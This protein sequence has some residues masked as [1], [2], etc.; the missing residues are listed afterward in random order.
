MTIFP[1]MLI[2]AS[3]L[4]SHWLDELAMF[5]LSENESAATAVAA[6]RHAFDTAF[7]ALQASP[8]RTAVFNARRE[9]FQKRKLPSAGFMQLLEQNRYQPEIAQLIESLNS[10]RKHLTLES[11]N[12]QE[13]ESALLSN[14]HLLQRVARDETLCRALL[15]ASHDLLERL[16]SFAQ[17]SVETFI[18]KDRQIALSL[19]QYL[20]RA[21]AKTSPLSR[22][23]TVG[24]KRIGQ[25]TEPGDDFAS[26]LKPH[27]TPNV[28]LL[29]ALY[30]VLLREIAFQRALSV[31]LNPCITH[32]TEESVRSADVPRSW[33][34]F[35]G[36][37]EAFQ[38][39]GANP[40]ADVVVKTLLGYNR[41][42]PFPQLLEY[43]ED[44]IDASQEQL[45][46][47]VYEL[48][49]YGLLEWELPEKGLTPG[50][51]GALYQFLGFLTDQPPVVSDAAGLLQWLRTAAR[52]LSFQ[53]LGA[54]MA[55]QREAV[56]MSHAFFENYGGKMPPIPPEQ[57]F[58]EDVAEMLA[59]DVPD[60]VIQSLANELAECWRQRR[61]KAFP[62]L[63]AQI[64]S[65]AEKELQE[66]QTIDFPVFYKRFLEH[67]K[68]DRPVFPKYHNTT[69]PEK[70]IG[71]LMQ[72][73]REEDGSYRAIVNGLFPG[74]GKLFSRWL[75]LFPI[76]TSDTLTQWLRALETQ[77]IPF[78][79]QGWSNANFQPAVSFESLSV[80][81]GR[82]AHLRGGRHISLGDLAIQF[83]KTG[84]QLIDK[85]T[86]K[87]VVLSELGLEAPESRPPAMQVLWHLGVPYVSLEAILQPRV[88]QPGGTDWRYADRIE[89][90]PLI[91]MRKTWQ[92]SEEK[93]AQW[94]SEKN[95]FDF[96]RRVRSDLSD[97]GVPRRY[98]SRHSGEKP[99]YF[100]L[101]CPLT[102]QLFTKILKQKKEPLIITEMI[103]MP[104]QYV[105]QK[106]GLR[107]AEYVIE[108]EI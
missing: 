93:T 94:L 18:K 38:Q 49:D 32:A 17:K 31:S 8:L 104:E 83:D 11:K 15:F 37:N 79:W 19:L 33:L 29:P 59:D 80:P 26:T 92:V 67:D 103:P 88:W 43:L 70:K 106:D 97:M 16:P 4:P 74:G 82:T 14:Y 1:L 90:G 101:D 48:I 84:L 58:F 12:I 24:L 25:V 91:L 13:Y 95:E 36:E 47:L 81:G 22:F 102:M 61:V 77:T 64:Y 3:G 53:T 9:F 35:D 89:V 40:V 87:P 65:F 85:E 107:A 42:L 51:C 50:W 27:V 99:Q 57:I 5:R 30:E 55:I 98:F 54:A 63:R 78:P 10:W 71:A 62:P 23:T 56:R 20:T 96:F 73:Y 86:N 66:G 6:V 100:D 60:T 45:Q 39:M 68:D 28:A 105:V 76:E 34:Y 44:E 7:S 46:H 69:P 2:R 108:F 21:A 41:A 75:H 72:I 52:T